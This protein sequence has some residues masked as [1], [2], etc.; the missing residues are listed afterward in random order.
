MTDTPQITAR[1]RKALGLFVSVPLFAMPA[2]AQ[3][4]TSIRVQRPSG[5][6]TNIR[7]GKRALERVGSGIRVT[8]RAGPRVGVRVGIR[9]P[10][11]PVGK[12]PI[13]GD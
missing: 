10:G 5:I 1:L 3:E 6:R 12:T 9:A 13:K 4:T 8:K 11:T 2:M 7:V